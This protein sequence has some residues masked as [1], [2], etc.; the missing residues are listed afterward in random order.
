MHEPKAWK[1]KNL[2]FNLESGTH[3]HSLRVCV[4]T[5]ISVCVGN[6]YINSYVCSCYTHV[7]T[8]MYVLMFMCAHSN[9]IWDPVG[10]EALTIVPSPS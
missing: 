9:T 7:Y 5:N 3:T 8:C 1:D 6:Y 10:L 2:T 4:T